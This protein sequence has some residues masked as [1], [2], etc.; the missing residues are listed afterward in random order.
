MGDFVAI[1][2]RDMGVKALC[3][4][5]GMRKI[6]LLRFAVCLSCLAIGVFARGFLAVWYRWMDGWANGFSRS[7]KCLPT[8]RLSPTSRDATLTD[9][10][11]T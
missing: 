7:I 3:I 9:D 2:R 5:Q 4:R 8:H 1:R 10:M 11:R 6:F